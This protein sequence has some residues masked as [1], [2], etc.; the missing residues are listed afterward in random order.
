MLW[1]LLDEMKL[2]YLS[3]NPFV[4]LGWLWLGVALGLFLLQ[5]RVLAFIL[6]GIAA[7][8]LAI[9][10]LFFGVILIASIFGGPI[11]WN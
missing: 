11:R 4:Y 8:P 10:A 2:V 9:M 5:F 3:V 7:L 6:V 1:W